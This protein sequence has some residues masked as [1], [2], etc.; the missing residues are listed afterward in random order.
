MSVGPFYQARR[1]VPA[2]SEKASYY[3]VN[4]ISGSLDK[5]A[6]TRR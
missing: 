1:F 4:I 6:W 2:F 3:K 5:A